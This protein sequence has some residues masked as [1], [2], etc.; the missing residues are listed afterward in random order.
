MP[1]ARLDKDQVAPP[2]WPVGIGPCR[3]SGNQGA[4]AVVACGAD[5]DRIAGDGFHGCGLPG[6]A[7]GGP[8]APDGGL[9]PALGEIGAAPRPA[10]AVPPVIVLQPPHQGV[11]GRRL[12]CRVQRGSQVIAPTVDLFLTEAGDGLTAGF[13]DEEVGVSILGPARRILRGQRPGQRRCQLAVIDEAVLVHFTQHPVAT[14]QG[15]L[16]VAFGVIVV[17]PLGQCGEEGRLIRG[18]LAQRLAEI[19]IGRRCDTIG[20]V[21]EENLVEIQLHDLLFG[22]GRFQPVGQDGFL[23]LAVD[24]ALIGQQDVLGHLLGYGRAAFKTPARGG[25]ED[26][27]EH[28]PAQAAHVDAAVVEEVP[29]LSGEEGLDHRQRDL[30]IRHIDAPLVRKLADQ[31][32]VAGIDPRRRR[33]PVVGQL[34]CVGQVMKQPGRIDGHDQPGQGNRPQQGHARHHEPAFGNLHLILRKTDSPDSFSPRR[35]PRLEP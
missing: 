1:A 28:G 16:G 34:G 4:R 11:T 14:A 5:T 13:L 12:Q 23:D 30:L 32:A 19:V 29:V 21:A 9:T 10:P 3:I 6:P 2:Q 24:A 26:V 25:V 17:R 7:L 18:Q 35:R 33:R 15:G 22:Q 31:G 8:L 20:A 27:L